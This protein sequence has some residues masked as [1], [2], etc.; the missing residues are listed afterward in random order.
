MPDTI[1]MTMPDGRKS[2]ITVE[3]MPDGTIDIGFIRA[4]QGAHLVRLPPNIARRLADA[5]QAELRRG[6]T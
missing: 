1:R 6:M 3:T 5:I 2:A 4:G